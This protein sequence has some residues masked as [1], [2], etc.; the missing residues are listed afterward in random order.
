MK[1]VGLQYWVLQTKNDGIIITYA[2]VKQRVYFNWITEKSF[3]TIQ[4]FEI[5]GSMLEMI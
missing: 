2:Q 5:L 3:E 4:F 1:I